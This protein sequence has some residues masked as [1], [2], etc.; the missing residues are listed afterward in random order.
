AKM[1]KVLLPAV[2]T[3]TTMMIRPAVQLPSPKTMCQWLLLTMVLGRLRSQQLPRMHR[4]KKKLFDPSLRAASL[5]TLP[6]PE[7]QQRPRPAPALHFPPELRASNASS[8]CITTPPPRVRIL[9]CEPLSPQSDARAKGL[10]YTVKERRYGYEC[11]ICGLLGDIRWI[12]ESPCKPKE[13]YDAKPKAS[14]DKAAVQAKQWQEQQD[15]LMATELQ[16][17][18]TE[19]KELEQLLVLQQLQNEEQLLEGLLQQKRA[20]EI[21]EDAA[22][23][24]LKKP[25]PASMPAVLPKDDVIPSGPDD[26]PD[27]TAGACQQAE[28]SVAP[29]GEV[30]S[31]VELKTSD[32]DAPPQGPHDVDSAA[33]E[34]KTSNGDAPPQGPHVDSATEPKTSDGDAPPQGDVAT[35]EPKTS[36][37][38]APPQG[39]VDSS[40]GPKGDAESVL[41]ACPVSTQPSMSPK[42]QVKLTHAVP[43][44]RASKKKPQPVDD[45]DDEEGD[46]GDDEDEGDSEAD[47]SGG[48]KT[49]ARAAG[50]G[51]GKGGRGRGRSTKGGGRGGSKE[52]RGRGGSKQGRGR[53]GSTKSRGRGGSKEGRGRGGSAKDCGRGGSSGGK[54]DAKVADAIVVEARAPSTKRANSD[55]AVKPKSKAKA[56]AGPPAAE[57]APKAKPKKA[58]DGDDDEEERRKKSRKSCAYHKAKA[59]AIKAGLSADQVKDAAK[60][61]A[62]MIVHIWIECFIC[63]LKSPLNPQP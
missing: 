3:A 39:D 47:S 63:V 9:L 43:K 12:R 24:A 20:L 50:R 18:E 61:V 31:A 1:E 4:R 29:E 2:T 35:T 26:V 45:D 13:D 5:V 57:A 56:K 51:R 19:E 54:A 8:E 14:P 53:G 21:A 59:N 44:R 7:L 28:E 52:G 6:A 22:A 25:K 17:L 58:R 36:D 15:L 46:D 62:C 48:S 40:T 10:H 37:G 11:L 49:K 16:R 38:D 42:Q 33:T 41:P 27:W 23:K 32:G 55:P 60:R 30:D 34:P